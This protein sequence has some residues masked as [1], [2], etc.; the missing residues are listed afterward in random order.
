[1]T[2]G[3]RSRRRQ[4]AAAAMTPPAR[5]SARPT[6]VPAIPIPLHPTRSGAAAPTHNAAALPVAAPAAHFPSRLAG[7]TTDRNVPIVIPHFSKLPAEAEST[8]APAE[9]L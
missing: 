8:R 9:Y 6:E 5:P 3:T 2:A 7:Q 4:T 1:M